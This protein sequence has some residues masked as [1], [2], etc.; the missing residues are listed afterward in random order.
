MPCYFPRQVLAS[1]LVD[2]PAVFVQPWPDMDSD[3]EEEEQMF[4][5][6]LEEETADAAQDEEHLMIL[7]CLSGLY[8]ESIIG[9][10]GSNNDI[11]VL[12]CSPGFSKLVERHAPPVNFVINGRQCKGYYLADGIYPKWA[13]FVKTIS[14]P[15]LPKEQ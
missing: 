14:S 15:A 4:A 10:R 7:A 5:E 12:Q 13:T 9:L 1:L 2:T 8:A 11:N 3:E 6:L